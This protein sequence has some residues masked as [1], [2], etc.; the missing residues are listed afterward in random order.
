MG[1]LVLVSEGLGLHLLI[2]GLVAGLAAMGIIVR[3]S[4]LRPYFGQILVPSALIA[5]SLLFYAVTFSFPKEKA[6]PAVIPHL[7]IF[8]TLVLSGAVLWRVFKGIGKPDPK[9]GRIGFLLM[10]IVLLAGY[11]LAFEILGYFLSSFIFMVILMHLLSYPKKS[12]IYSAAAGWVI[13]C[14]VV[15]Y[16]LLHIQLP[17]GFLGEYFY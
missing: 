3:R 11:Y 7:W 16:R 15:F 10:I 2:G 6:G 12:V 13:F 17:L 14:Y 8:W 5:L 4:R 1:F 9:T